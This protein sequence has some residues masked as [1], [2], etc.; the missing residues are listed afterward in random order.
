MVHYVTLNTKEHGVPPHTRVHPGFIPGSLI[1]EL[2]VLQVT[3]LEV[4]QLPGALQES[5]QGPVYESLLRLGTGR[6][7]QIRAQYAASGCPIYG[8]ALYAGMAPGA[9]RLNQAQVWQHLHSSLLEAHA[10]GT[11]LMAHLQGLP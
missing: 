2:E 3:Q 10:L 4:H 7:H 11:V 1:C 5:W 6:T 8:D 9:D